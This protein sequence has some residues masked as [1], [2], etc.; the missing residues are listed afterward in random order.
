MSVLREKA[1]KAE[2]V[3]FVTRK[4]AISAGDFFVA[5]C[6]WTTL[7][8]VGN[9]FKFGLDRWRM[10]DAGVQHSRYAEI[11]HIGESPVILSEMSSRVIDLPTILNAAGP[12][13]G[14]PYAPSRKGRAL[15]TVCL[16]FSE[17]AIQAW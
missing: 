17:A 8:D 1:V 13:P 10:D 9:L 14:R 4:S 16:R 7:I 2:T 15:F 3:V 11:L 6:W 5:L 12:T